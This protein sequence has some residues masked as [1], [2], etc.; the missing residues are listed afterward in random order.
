MR[1]AKRMVRLPSE[2]TG[3]I[4]VALAMCIVGSSVAV[5]KVVAAEIPVFL[6]S[7]LRF[8]IAA[9]CI[10]PLHYVMAGSLRLPPLKVGLLLGAQA[11]L[12]CFCSRCVCCWD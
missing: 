8:V 3:H 11:F 2:L 6:T 9:L 5:G 10:L 12:V 4:Q 7:F 1:T